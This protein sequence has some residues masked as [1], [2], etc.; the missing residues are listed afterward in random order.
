MMKLL[1]SVSLLE[2][3]EQQKSRAAWDR[4]SRAQEASHVDVY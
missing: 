4:F 2:L 3:V 1:N